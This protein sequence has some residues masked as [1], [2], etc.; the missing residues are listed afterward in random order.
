VRAPKARAR[1]IDASNVENQRKDTFYVV[2]RRKKYKNRTFFKSCRTTLV[3]VTIRVQPFPTQNE[4]YASKFSDKCPFTPHFAKMFFNQAICKRFQNLNMLATHSKFPNTMWFSTLR[5]LERKIL[6]ILFANSKKS[7]PLGY[8]VPIYD[9]STFQVVRQCVVHLS[10]V[11]G[12]NRQNI[13]K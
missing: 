2:K 10:C 7:A 9:P 12:V 3:N 8:G 4:T 13:M 11:R 1:E 6:G 5:R